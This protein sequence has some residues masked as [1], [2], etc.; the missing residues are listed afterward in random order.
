MKFLHHLIRSIRFPLRMLTMVFVVL[1]LLWDYQQGYGMFAAVMAGVLAIP[2]GEYLGRTKIRSYIFG[3]VFLIGVLLVQMFGA[4]I[5][6]F[7]FVPSI[8]GT[9]LTLQIQSM[10]YGFGFVFS[11]CLCFENIGISPH[12]FLCSRVLGHRVLLRLCFCSSSKSIGVTSIMV[13]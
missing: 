9:G 3:F 11:R 2:M 10:L 13:E 7:S 12:D 4:S 5:G 8:L 1:S 6:Y